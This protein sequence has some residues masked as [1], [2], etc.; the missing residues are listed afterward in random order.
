MA[1]WGARPINELLTYIQSTMPPGTAGGLGPETYVNL[2][3][4]LLEANGARA[5]NQ[6]LSLKTA[7]L[8]RS[9]A[10]GEMPASLRQALRQGS[11]DVPTAYQSSSTEEASP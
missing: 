8:I 1:A 9:A 6:P 3:A 2:V 5:G 11:A 10:T 4:F 7:S